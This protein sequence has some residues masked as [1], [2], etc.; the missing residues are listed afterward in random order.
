MSM[1]ADDMQMEYEPDRRETRAGRRETDIVVLNV[2]D[3]E[4]RLTALERSVS[5]LVADIERNV[6]NPLQELIKA[7]N[8]MKA[9][10]D[11][12][13]KVFCPLADIARWLM[14]RLLVVAALIAAIIAAITHRWDD[15]VKWLRG[16]L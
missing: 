15:A 2:A 7:L 5:R 11:L 4:A 9:V 3:H 8:W 13:R 6:S 14:Q 12:A 1:T 10:T 16:I